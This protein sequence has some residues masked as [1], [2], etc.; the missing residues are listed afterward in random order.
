MRKLFHTGSERRAPVSGKSRPPILDAQWGHEPTPNPSEDGSGISRLFPSREGSG[1]GSFLETESGT[2]ARSNV[3][4]NPERGAS[5][6]PISSQADPAPADVLKIGR[7]I[8]VAFARE[9]VAFQ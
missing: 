2:R 1:V 5:G 7:G 8:T 3:T 6:M 4:C 9:I